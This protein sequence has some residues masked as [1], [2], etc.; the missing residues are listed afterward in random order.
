MKHQI[1]KGNNI[2]DKFHFLYR[3]G[4]EENRLSPIKPLRL[5]NK[6]HTLLTSSPKKDEEDYNVMKSLDLHQRAKERFIMLYC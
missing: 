1:G 6:S 4:P 5:P 3:K 2:T